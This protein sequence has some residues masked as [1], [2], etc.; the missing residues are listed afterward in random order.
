MSLFIKLKCKKAPLFMKSTN[1]DPVGISGPSKPLPKTSYLKSAKTKTSKTSLRTFTPQELSL[2]FPKISVKMPPQCSAFK[3]LTSM[4][5]KR[6]TYS[7]MVDKPPTLLICTTFSGKMQTKAYDS[8]MDQFKCHLCLMF[9][10]R[11]I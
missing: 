9:S 5:S 3:T 11:R 4:R 10:I 1:S 2:H 6:L 7:H 8:I